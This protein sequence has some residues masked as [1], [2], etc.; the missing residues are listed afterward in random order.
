VPYALDLPPNSSLLSAKL[1]SSQTADA[2]AGAGA[3]GGHC[4]E[5][6]VEAEGRSWKP[7]DV[8]GKSSRSGFASFFLLYFF[9]FDRTRGL[10]D[11]FTPLLEQT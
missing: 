6:R 5:A 3:S 8:E 4:V 2:D 7:C 9:P 10:S 1:C 11:L